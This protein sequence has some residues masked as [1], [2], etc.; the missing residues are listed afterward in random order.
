[1]SRMFLRLYRAEIE[2]SK[3]SPANSSISSKLHNI[4]PFY[5]N[6]AGHYGKCFCIPTPSPYSTHVPPPPTFEYDFFTKRD[7]KSH[8]LALARMP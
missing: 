8:A 2:L 4:L 1:M 6:F 3:F 5:L 7:T